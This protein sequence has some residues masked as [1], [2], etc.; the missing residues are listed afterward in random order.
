[1][2]ARL[3]G[4]RPLDARFAGRAARQVRSDPLRS[5]VRHARFKLVAASAAA[6]APDARSSPNV[7]TGL[8]SRSL[9]PSD[10]SALAAPIRLVG[11]M[12]FVAAADGRTGSS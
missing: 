10:P 2:A 1:M 6:A 12:H 5:C 4:S 11:S 3:G 8:A 7:S 9:L